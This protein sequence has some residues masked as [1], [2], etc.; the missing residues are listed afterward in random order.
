MTDR[1]VS[2]WQTFHQFAAGLHAQSK[3]VGLVHYLLSGLQS[4]I[5]SDY[6]S[7]KEITLHNGQA[8]ITGV[9]SPHNP[10]AASLLPVFQRHVSEHPVCS[11]WLQSGKSNGAFSWN[12]VATRQDIER[13][14]L[15]DEFYRPLGIHHQMMIAMEVKPSHLVYLAMNRSHSPFTEQ[16]RH[17]LGSLQPHASQAFCHMREIHHLQSTLSSFETLV[18]TLNQ[19]IVCLSPHNRIKWASKRGRTYLQAYFGDALHSTHLPDA[20]HAWL[21]AQQMAAGTDRSIQEPLT[22]QR[23]THRL[24]IRLLS[25]K[26]ERYVFMEE[27][28]IQPSFDELKRLGL[29]D[30]EAQV[31]GWVSQGKSNEDT[32][33]ILKIGPQTV[34]KHLERIYSALR[35]ANRTEAALKAHEILYRKPEG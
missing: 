7:W 4:I 1:V 24:A 27:I 34:K 13:L 20:L 28:S 26:N 35:V 10:K 23:G 14:P 11:H 19:G 15:Y 33:L 30:R 17:L 21:L 32:A 12:D 2:S 22:I 25:K 3:A 6:N 31:L 5:P 29:T 9:F 18:D 8:Q 16:E